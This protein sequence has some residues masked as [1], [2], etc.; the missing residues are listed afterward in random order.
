MAKN[1]DD[2]NLDSITNIG[3]GS[4]KYNETIYSCKY[5]F[6]FS[7]I[8]FICFYLATIKIDSDSFD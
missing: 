2:I 5:L 6:Q 8:S 4:R 1:K 7:L 3:I